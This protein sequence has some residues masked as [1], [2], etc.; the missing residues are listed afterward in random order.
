VKSK[1]AAGVIRLTARHPRLGEKSV[2]IVVKAHRQE[3]V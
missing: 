2:E 1:Q 3:T